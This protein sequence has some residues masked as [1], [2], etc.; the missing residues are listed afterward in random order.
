MQLKAKE[1]EHAKTLQAAEAKQAQQAKALQAAEAIS[2]QAEASVKKLKED[3]FARQAKLEAAHAEALQQQREA[4]EQ[5]YAVR[6]LIFDL[7]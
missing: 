4:V 6:V 5:E 1:A 7:Q 2:K 3:H